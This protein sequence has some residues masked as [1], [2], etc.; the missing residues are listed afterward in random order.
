MNELNLKGIIHRDLKDQN[1]L[2]KD[3]MIKI[4]DFGLAR[5]LNKKLEL[6]SIR[7]GTPHTMAPEIYFHPNKSE[8]NP[9]YTFKAD[10]YSI[11]VIFH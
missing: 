8:L 4:G 10:I 9:I 1:I 5:K 6:D 7:C 2:I 11:A 3:E